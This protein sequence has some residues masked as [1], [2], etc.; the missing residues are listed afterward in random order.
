MEKIK[1]LIEKCN[2]C[3]VCFDVCPYEAINI[4]NNIPVIDE[5]C[6]LCGVCVS[7]CEQKAILIEK[8]GIREIA[9]VDLSKY[10]NV[11]VF[12]EQYEGK[13]AP[14]TLELL[15]KGK[16]LAENIN[17]KLLCIL[18]GYNILEKSKD[19]CSYAD[20]VY[21]YDNSALKDFKIDLYT[22]II[23]NLAEEIKPNIILFGA[24]PIG[25]SLAPRIAVRLRTG[26]TADCTGLDIDKDGNLIQT[27][28]AF[29][30]NVMAN[31]L[32]TNSRPQMA[33]VRY[34]VMKKAEKTKSGKIIIKDYSPVLSKIDI[35]KSEKMLNGVD[36]V[37]ADIIVSGGKGLGKPDGF[38]LLKEFTSLIGGSIG[39]SRAVVDEGWIDHIHQVGLSGRTVRPKLY[40]ACGISGSVQ[41]LAGMKT[42]E[43]IVAINKDPDAPIFKVAHYGIVGD[44]YEVIPV[45]MK[46]I[47]NRRQKRR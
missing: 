3:K 7:A 21:I 23:S 38:K 16:E 26:L 11:L 27:R 41:H 19:L 17:E 22:N 44:L 34:K 9:K 10:K 32:C 13:L 35:V 30:G 45:L 8:E 14:V 1:I 36:I 18:L 28:P 24:T 31:I 47:I 29:G 20:K 12:A 6:Q 43:T 2:G 40:I 5:N 15:G 39:A 37:D 25:R 33:T 46:E 42:S 4:I